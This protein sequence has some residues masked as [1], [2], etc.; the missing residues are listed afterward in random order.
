L[1][2]ILVVSPHWLGDAVMSHSLIKAIDSY[3]KITVL[4]PLWLEPLFSRMKE[5]TK[6]YAVNFK[7]QKL[8]LPLH[9]S[10][11]FKVKKDNFDEAIIIP[12]KLKASLIP[13]F[14]RIQ[15]RTGYKNI[16]NNNK[17]NI[18][19]NKSISYIKKI[20][21]LVGSSKKPPNPSL[22][23]D[24][25]KQNFWQKKINNNYI[26]AF[27]P[28]ASFGKSKQYPAESFSK[29]SFLLQEKGYKI[30]LL[31]G[32]NEIGICK[33]IYNKNKQI[34]NFCGKTSITDAIDILSFCKYAITCDSGLMHVAAAT[35]CHTVAIYGGSSPDYTPP[36]TNNKTIISDNLVCQPCFKKECQY[37]TYECFAKITPQNI[38]SNVTQPLKINK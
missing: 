20:F 27:M 5:V 36:M 2:N 6:I 26:I 21:K 19:T 32:K 15:Q 25:K 14:A 38:A 12:R 3:A 13:Y 23:I 8:Q 11:A 35:G 33:K 22:Q 18:P 4:C 9:F 37:Q 24:K 30:V 29:L 34:L 1:K 10:T 31:G 17:K 7:H 16:F 28:G